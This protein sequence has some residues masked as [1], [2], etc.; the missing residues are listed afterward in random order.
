MSSNLRRVDSTETQGINE[1]RVRAP[2]PDRKFEEALSTRFSRADMQDYAR[3]HYYANFEPQVDSYTEITRVELR[4]LSEFLHAQKE[5]LKT[6]FSINQ[7][8]TDA[9]MTSPTYP[10]PAFENAIINEPE[11]LRMFARIAYYQEF[12]APPRPPG[13]RQLPPEDIVRVLAFV[14]EYMATPKG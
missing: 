6:F 8:R 1:A 7:K 2:Y 4:E 5:R 11:D 14:E 3:L 10:D 9:N 13:S 12:G